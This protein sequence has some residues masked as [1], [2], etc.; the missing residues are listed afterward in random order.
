MQVALGQRERCLPSLP[1][2]VQQLMQQ[3]SLDLLPLVLRKLKQQARV[4]VRMQEPGP[5]LA[6]LTASQGRVLLAPPK[7]PRGTA[8]AELA[9][10]QAQRSYRCLHEVR[11][12]HQP[13]S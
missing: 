7:P 13:A 1:A 12:E 9:P 3:M 4:Q 10:Q 2:L 8:P 6:A 11:M 5:A